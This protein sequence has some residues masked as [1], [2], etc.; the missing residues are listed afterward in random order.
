MFSSS[1]S[2]RGTI[3]TEWYNMLVKEQRKNMFLQHPTK[4][5]SLLVSNKKNWNFRITVQRMWFQTTEHNFTSTKKSHENLNRERCQLEWKTFH[6]F[7]NG[8]SPKHPTKVS[9]SQISKKDRNEQTQ[10]NKAVHVTCTLSILKCNQ[11]CFKKCLYSLLS[12]NEHWFYI[13]F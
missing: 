5:L 4:L 9:K 2:G 8:Q 11:N 7:S 3:F 6:F 12:W 1:F 10:G 13:L